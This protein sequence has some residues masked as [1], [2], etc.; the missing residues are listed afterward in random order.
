M[1]LKKSSACGLGAWKGLQPK[2]FWFSF[3]AGTFSAYAAV[4]EDWLERAFVRRGRAIVDQIYPDANERTRLYQYG[5][6]PYVGRRFEAIA[7]EMKAVIERAQDYGGASAEDRFAI[8]VA[9]GEL[10]AADRGYGFRVRATETDREL[11]E[12]WQDVLGWWVL[13]PGA[14]S[15]DSGA[16]SSLATVCC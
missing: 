16:A 15:P 9:L 14:A 7:P 3:G 1:P 5:F 2:R 13:A 4:Q 8:L 11:L 6:T 12:N 10:I